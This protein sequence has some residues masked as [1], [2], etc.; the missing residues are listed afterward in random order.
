[1][2]QKHSAEL[3]LLDDNQCTYADVNGDG[4]VSVID[5]T[6]IQKY[7]AELISEF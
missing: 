4:K 2:I 6:L 1:M 5:A 3:E 7:S